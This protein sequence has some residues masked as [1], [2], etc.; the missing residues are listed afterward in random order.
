MRAWARR[1]K[2]S[3]FWGRPKTWSGGTGRAVRARRRAVG[4]AGQ[5]AQEEVLLRGAVFQPRLP[6][7]GQE[8]LPLV[9]PALVHHPPGEGGVRRELGEEGGQGQARSP[10]S[11]SN[12]ASVRRGVPR[13]R[14]R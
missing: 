4:G 6:G 14:G 8:D 5:E 13:E 12:S 9:F 3:S 1:L 10:S 7:R 2:R 11:F